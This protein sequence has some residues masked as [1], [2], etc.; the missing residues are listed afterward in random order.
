MLA[1]AGAAL[2]LLGIT[3]FRALRDLVL[4]GI[5]SLTCGMMA[6]AV[7]PTDA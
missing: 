6:Y 2:V 3:G 4:C 1:F 7:I 5:C